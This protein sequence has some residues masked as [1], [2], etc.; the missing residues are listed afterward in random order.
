MFQRK[1]KG[2]PNFGR[3]NNAPTSVVN[4]SIL[5]ANTP[6]KTANL[7]NAATTTTPTH[8]SSNL[9]ATLPSAPANVAIPRRLNHLAAP[10]EVAEREDFGRDKDLKTLLKH[11]QSKAFKGEGTRYTQNP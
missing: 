7:P 11:L 8:V 9:A 5:A 4:N 1:T 2:N 6:T 3:R 10:V